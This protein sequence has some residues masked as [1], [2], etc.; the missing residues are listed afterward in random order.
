MS[1]FQYY[2]PTKVYFG[3]GSLEKLATMD[4]PGKKAMICMTEGVRQYAGKIVELLE[5]NG[6]STV[7]FDQV[8]PN[9]NSTGVMK[10]V[11]LAQENG[12]DFLIGLGGGSSV[13]TAK[14]AAVV[15]ANGG[16]VWEYMGGMTGKL[17]PVKRALPVVA[18]STTSGTGTEVNPFAV[19]TKEETCEKIDLSSESVYPAISIID[20]T[21]QMTV[22]AALTACQ[23]MDVLFHSAEGYI[24]NCA[25]PISNLYALES[26]K[27]VARYLP[28]AVKDGSDLEAREG[29]CLAN[30]YAGIVESTSAS[31]SEHAIGH[32]LG[33][34][35]TSTPHGMALCLV[36]VECFKYYARYVPQLL[37]DMAEAVGY[38]KTPESF[39]EFLEDLLEQVG[40]ARI[41]Y[42]QWGITPERAEE[43]ARNSYEVTQV[44]HDSDI[45][46]MPLEDCVG[47]IERS[48]ARAVNKEE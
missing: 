29:M 37:A 48:L 20:P 46:P 4:L 30:L 41:D 22:P 24:A 6:V 16:D 47:I 3:N 14:A 39:V 43:Y 32:S 42:T 18:I 26:I 9:P 31:T 1:D 34:M 17:K 21:L 15:M 25:T 28:R 23:G 7:I 45:H 36:C 27:L 44:L 33:A 2:V 40:L 35:H 10:A 13:D 12:V 5:Q 38:P 8:Q 11:A 19:I